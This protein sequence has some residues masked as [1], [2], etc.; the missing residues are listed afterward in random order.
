MIARFLRHAKATEKYI[1]IILKKNIFPDPK[2][3]AQ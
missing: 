2:L 3:I 1:Q